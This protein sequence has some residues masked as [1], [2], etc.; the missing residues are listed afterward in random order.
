MNKSTVLLFASAALLLAACGSG[1][2]EEPVVP[3]AEQVPDTASAS[4]AGM[5]AWMTDLSVNPSDT[6][7]PLVA[8]RFMP[9]TPDN[10]EPEVLK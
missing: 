3:V 5:A 7:E 8:T 6:K 2:S 4:A 9:P 1:G 10:T